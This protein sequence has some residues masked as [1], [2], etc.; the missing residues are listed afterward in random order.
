MRQH[1][2][3]EVRLE[4]RLSPGDWS[5]RCSIGKGSEVGNS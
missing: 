2:Y 1:Q 3:R 5:A 4:E